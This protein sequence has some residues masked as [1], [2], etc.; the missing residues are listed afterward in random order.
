MTGA[1]NATLPMIRIDQTRRGRDQV[2]AA[3]G[4][5]RSIYVSD[6]P[7]FD[8]LLI[9]QD[10]SCVDRTRMRLHAASTSSMPSRPSANRRRM[11]VMLVYE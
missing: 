11:V 5:R 3:L 10:D 4:D 6:C 1:G 7:K 2:L 9:G 8:A